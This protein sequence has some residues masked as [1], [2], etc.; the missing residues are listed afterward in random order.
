MPLDLDREALAG[1]AAAQPDPL[2]FATVSGAHLYGFPSRDSDIDLRGAHLLPLSELVG[3][4]EGEQ[5]RV[6]IW[7]ADAPDGDPAGVE[8]DLVTH[9]LGK[10]VRLLLRRNGYVLEQLLSPLVVHTIPAHAELVELAPGLVTRHHAHHYAGFARTQTRLYERT[11]ELKPLLY[12]FR[13]LLTGIYLMRSGEV[14]ADLPA[15]AAICPAEAPAYVPDLVAAKREAEHGSAHGLV[16]PTVA[17]TDIVRLHAA[18]D[19]AQ[20]VSALPAR[21]SGHDALHDLLVRARLSRA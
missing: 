1:I 11:G 6:R 7:T 5:T 20:A 14:V 10:F 9:D 8:N 2:V 19:A 21:P 12:P 3:L 15:L 18:L 17:G 4:R 16:A 13:V